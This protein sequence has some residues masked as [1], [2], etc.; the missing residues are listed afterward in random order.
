MRG[1]HRTTFGTLLTYW[2]S[3]PLGSLNQ[4]T[5]RKIA[6]KKY[7]LLFLLGSMVGDK[8]FEPLTSSM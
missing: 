6:A 1:S 4:G 7:K 2:T 8:G 5:V 3:Q